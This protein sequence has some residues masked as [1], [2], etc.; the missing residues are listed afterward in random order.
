METKIHTLKFTYPQEQSRTVRVYVPAHEEGET[1]PVVYMTD[2]Q[3]LFEAETTR[4]G[5]WLTYKAVEDE[6]E[7]N[8]RSAIIVGIHN[9]TGPIERTR[10]LTPKSIGRLFFPPDMPEQERLA[11]MPLGESFDR[12]V[13]NTVMP[14]ITSDFPVKTGKE[15]TAF[16][17]SSSGGLQTFFTA[18]SHPDIFSA[19]GVF[20]PCF[21]MYYPDDLKKWI[22]QSVK[23]DMPYLY[24]YSG[25]TGM[26]ESIICQSTESTWKTL[27]EYYPAEK[28][29]KVIV[30]ENDHNE[31]AWADI[32]KDF[33]HIFLSNN[34]TK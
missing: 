19:A 26:L 23:D 30:P 6:Q 12:F 18:L 28:M 9:D 25:G 4:F 27:E 13:I 22:Q 5:S 20:S 34:Y 32:F 33:L 21:M 8:G 1:L 24:I 17:G 11:F 10:E 14:K 7:K 2:G 29:K 31:A 3:N 15:N 16:C